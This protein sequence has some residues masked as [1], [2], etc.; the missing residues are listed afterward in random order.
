MINPILLTLFD[1][2]PAAIKVLI[3]M[4]SKSFF[5][6]NLVNG[7]TGEFVEFKNDTFY[8]EHGTE[9]K[10]V[11][12]NRHPS[13][14]ADVKINV[15]GKF[16]GIFRSC[17]GKQIEIERPVDRE[18]KLTFYS[19]S[20]EEG[21]KSKLSRENKNLGTIEI[22][23][24]QEVEERKVRAVP[25]C[26]VAL[27]CSNNCDEDCADGG[28]GLGRSS[29]QMTAGGTGLGRSSQQKFWTAE[30]LDIDS[31]FITLVA[32]MKLSESVEPL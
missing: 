23:I 14:R 21:E 8:L 25:D 2:Q 15:D 7:K 29:Q 11:V 17:P 5:S 3:K 28:T 20:S 18:K 22:T 16:V 27:G 30:Q 1:F 4:L 31:N 9:Y 13:R 24:K 19:L 10:I 26:A 32:K 6:L 12:F